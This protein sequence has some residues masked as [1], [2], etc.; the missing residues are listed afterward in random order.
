[1]TGL[2]RLLRAAALAGLLAAGFSSWPAPSE[3]SAA[4]GRLRAYSW[5][6]Q[7]KGMWYEWGGIGPAG[8]DCSG[9]VMMAYRSAGISLPRTTYEMLAD[10]FSG[11]LIPETHAQARRG[12][13]AFFGTGHVEMFDWGNITFGAHDSGERIGYAFF[14]GGWQPTMYFRIAGAG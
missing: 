9:L 4:P 10:V 1:M 2:K 12:D 11:K 14:G 7:K 3:A 5:A 6:L 8:Y 13:L